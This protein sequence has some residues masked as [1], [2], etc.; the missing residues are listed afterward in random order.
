MNCKD[1]KFWKQTTN[2]NSDAVA[3]AGDCTELH[4]H[5][6]IELHLGW[7]GGYVQS[8]ETDGD[9]G[10]VKFEKDETEV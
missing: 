4:Y 3:D 9:F 5:L 6:E 7:E 10:C 8:I 2:Y 1:C